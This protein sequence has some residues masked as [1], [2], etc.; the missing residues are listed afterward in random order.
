MN[1]HDLPRAAL[2]IVNTSVLCWLATYSPDRGPNVSPKEVFTIGRDGRLLVANIAS[3]RSALNLALEPRVCC[4]FVD[5][6]RQKGVK[7]IGAGREVRRTDAGFDALHA[8]FDPAVTAAFPVRSVFEIVVDDVAWI[9]AP[10]YTLRPGTTEHAQIEQ[11]RRRHAL[12]LQ[13]AI[14]LAGLDPPP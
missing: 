3:P 12:A 2:D 9:L 14:R 8:Q 6:Y 11:A 1:L 7:L 10:S 4:V 5:L 13:D